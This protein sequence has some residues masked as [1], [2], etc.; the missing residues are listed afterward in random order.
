MIINDI[1]I[2][3]VDYG[4]KSGSPIVLLHGWGQ[5]IEM[6]QGLGDNFSKTNRIIIIDLPGFGKSS[7]PK[8]AWNFEEYVLFLEEFL[9]KLDVSNPIIIGHSFGGKIGLLYSSRNKVSKLV[10]LASPNKKK[11]KKDYIKTKLLKTAKKV[12]E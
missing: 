9:N 1:N 4:N 8:Y 12:Q 11:I 10:S 5:N 3:Y 6:M 2:N 7:E